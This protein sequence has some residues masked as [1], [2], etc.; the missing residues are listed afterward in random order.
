MILQRFYKLEI[1]IPQKGGLVRKNSVR[2]VYQPSSDAR[3]HKIILLKI[4][5]YE[6]PGGISL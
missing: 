4:S 1:N 5:L 2:V 6:T 3:R